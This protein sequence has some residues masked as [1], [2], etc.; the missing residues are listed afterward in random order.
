MPLIVVFDTNILLS[1]LLSPTSN[2]SKCLQ[3]ARSGIIQSV[4]CQEIIDEFAEKLTVKFKYSPNESQEIISQFLHYSKTIQIT[5]TLNVV[6]KDADDNKIIECAIVGLANYII[7]G[8]KK[9]L[10]PIG[11]YQGI[12]IVNGTNFLQ[13]L[14]S[15][16]QKFN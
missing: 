2:P 14:M 10:L 5:N 8:D 4:T 3:L 13:I 6:E 9:H 1:A 11:N 15:N 12:S 7:T 16:N